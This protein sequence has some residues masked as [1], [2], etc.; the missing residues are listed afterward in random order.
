MPVTQET[1]QV[2]TKPRRRTHTAEYKRRTLKEADARAT[3]GA[4]GTLLQ[5]EGLYSSNLAALRDRPRA[6]A[7][8]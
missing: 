6:T 5:R 4:I 3:P 7:Q 2:A 8:P 1:V